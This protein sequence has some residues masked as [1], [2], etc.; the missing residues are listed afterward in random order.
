[1]D[2]LAIKP[3]RQHIRWS[4]PRRRIAGVSSFGVSGTNA[5]VVIEEAPEPA[6]L[7]SACERPLHFLA[8][9]AKTPPALKRLADDLPAHLEK[10]SGL[11]LGDVCFT[12]NSRAVHSNRAAWPVATAEEARDRLREFSRRRTPAA[13]DAMASAPPRIAFVLAGEAA[14]HAGIWGEL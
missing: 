7:E 13:D 9:S 2:R 5:H 10:N 11:S 8:I 6:V 12:L 1:W 14:A 3:V 4:P